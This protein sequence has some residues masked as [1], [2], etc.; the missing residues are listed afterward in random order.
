MKNKILS[1]STMQTQFPSTILLLL[2]ILTTYHFIPSLSQICNPNDKNALLQIKKQ[3]GN[4]SQLSSWDPTTD[5]C[6]T[7]WQ[8]ASC[9][10]FTPTYR[11]TDLD[12]S[13]LQLS[14]PYPIPPSITNL[15][16]LTLLSLANIPNLVGPIPP[17]IVN[18][19]I[20]RYL[21]I[22][23]TNI[24]GEIPGILS[25]IKTLVTI[26]FTNN[27][28][29]G[30]LPASLSSLPV[31]GGI[32]FDSNQL[33]GAIPESYGSFSKTLFTGLTLSRNKLSG[34]IPAS[35]A[36]LNLAFL[37][38]SRNAL[39][40]DASVFFGSKKETQQIVLGNNKFGFDFGKVGLSKNLEKLDLRNNKIYGTLPEG[41]TAL[42]FL[43]KLNVSSN[44][45]CGQIPSLRFDET[46]YAHNKCLCGS[47]LPPCKT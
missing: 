15:P 23:N 7:T 38:L 14:Q 2:L 45:L 47:P 20:L 5:C 25:Q 26:T 32:S 43:H 41:L 29:T 11:I 1:S 37:D 13:D 22:R 44:N 12:L 28:L 42:K 3:L 31:L 8:G 21:T 40:G 27:K 6:N 10:T 39:E 4:P 18:L 24:S 17:S 46:S 16:A 34:K 9:D 35:L 30:P 36:N 33:T 19:T